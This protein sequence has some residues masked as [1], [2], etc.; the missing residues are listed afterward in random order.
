MERK[1]NIM[2]GG[3][4]YMSIILYSTGCPKCNVLEAKL[5]SKSI[6][7][8]VCRD[9]EVMQSK[10]MMSA[11]NLEVDGELMDFSAAIKWVREYKEMPDNNEEQHQTTGT[12]EVVSML[13][14]ENRL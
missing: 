6:K 12:E 10:G 9:I 14:R 8:E 5:N 7:Y 2:L 1:T 3:K 11:P 13:K 4:F